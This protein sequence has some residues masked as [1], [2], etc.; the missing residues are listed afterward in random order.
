M[1]NK[2]IHSLVEQCKEKLLEEFGDRIRDLVVEDDKIY[3]L[4]SSADLPDV[5]DFVY[6]KLG[7]YLVNVAGS[8]E[9]RYNGSYGLYYIFSIEDGLDEKAPKP[10]I[11]VYT[12]VPQYE[13]VLPSTTSRVPAASW[14]ERE[15]MDLLGLKAEGHPDP[16]RLVLPDDWPE[17]VYP[18]R[19]DYKYDFRPR[20]QAAS[21]EYRFRPDKV[22]GEEIVSIPIGPVH[23]VAD[24][25]VQ[26]R[27][28]VDGERIV[29]VDYRMVYVHRGVEKLAVSRMTYDQ[30]PFIA[31]RICGI[32][33]YV[34]A[35]CY[36]QAVENAF[37][38]DVPD[39]ARYIRTILLEIERIHSHLLH[40]GLLCHMAAF[41]W[42]FMQLF[43]LR[44]KIMDLAEILTG[45][46]KTYGANIIGGVRRDIIKDRIDKALDIVKKTR[47][48]FKEYMDTVFSSA[49]FMKRITNVGVLERK[50][51]RALSVVGPVARGSG[52]PRDVRK[53]HPYA[54]YKELS[55]KVPV[56][57][58]GDVLARTMVRVE[59]VY[60]SLNILEEALDK[61]PGGPIALE[62][63]EPIEMVK[64]LSAVEAPRGEDSHFIIIGKAGRLLRWKVRAPT[65][66][67]WPA[68]PPMSRDYLVADFPVIAISIDPCYSCTE[69][70]VV[71]N[72]RD[73]SR[74]ILSFNYLIN[75]FRKR[76]T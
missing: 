66:N 8:D 53:D 45:N 15:V 62:N 20:Y 35:C 10:W 6:W 76:M 57:S 28:F 61:L 75:K 71:I 44:E 39:R 30:I 40:L 36:A 51:A 13:L 41:D 29:D 60:E 26:F 42:G 43:K 1:T 49:P 4:I 47:L 12:Y 65:Y 18:L 3:V 14:Y 5:T 70:V 27:L 16:R 24:E 46:R 19:E 72:V 64:G 48:E 74:K 59:E 56:Y 73:N 33:G 37:K 7:G 68:I 25:P 52:L 69:R 67:N 32:C 9:R 50:V 55:F 22:E 11:I 34:H 21:Y 63:I 58:E 38:I 2:I 54:A 31:D 17:G 23:P